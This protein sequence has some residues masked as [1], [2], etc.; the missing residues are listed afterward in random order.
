LAITIKADLRIDTRRPRGIGNQSPLE[1]VI[2]VENTT[3][4]LQVGNGKAFATL[5]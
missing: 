3:A 2:D 4:G 5:I 1:A